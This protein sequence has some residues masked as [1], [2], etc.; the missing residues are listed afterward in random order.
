LPTLKR[1]R[2]RVEHMAALAYDEIPAFM[3]KLRAIDDNLHR[4]VPGG[5]SFSSQNLSE[6]RRA[7][8]AREAAQ[9]RELRQM[10]AQPS[11]A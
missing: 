7:D 8:I 6:A 3:A 4:A 11:A 10:S 2:E 9:A 1:K 5:L